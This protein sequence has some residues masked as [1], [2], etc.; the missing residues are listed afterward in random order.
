MFRSLS[1][2]LFQAYLAIATQCFS[3]TTPCEAGVIVPLAILVYLQQPLYR[4]EE[5]PDRMMVICGKVLLVTV[6][7]FQREFVVSENW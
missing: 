3:A 5:I 4:V 1:T 7:L 2:I 6:L